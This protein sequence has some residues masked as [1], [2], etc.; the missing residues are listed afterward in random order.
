MK[1]PKPAMPTMPTMPGK[2][3]PNNWP[4]ANPTNNL[5]PPKPMMPKVG[6]AKGKKA[7]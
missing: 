1:M 2:K 3:R 6:M 4:N 5:M 7:C